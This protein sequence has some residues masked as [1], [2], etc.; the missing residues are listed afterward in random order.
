MVLD[1]PGI[2]LIERPGNSTKSIIPRLH[3]SIIPIGVEPQTSI[4]DLLKEKGLYLNVFRLIFW[5]TD[6]VEI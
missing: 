1:R 6:D 2:L 4:L 3:Y 5:K